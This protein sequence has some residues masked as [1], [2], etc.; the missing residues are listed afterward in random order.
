MSVDVNVQADR[1][2]LPRRTRYQ[3]MAQILSYNRRTYAAAAAVAALLLAGALLLP[4]TGP[5]RPVRVLLAAMGLLLLAG[6]AGSLLA[7]H[8]VYDRSALHRWTWLTERVPSGR[9]G[10]RWL[11]VHAGLDEAS[12]ALRALYGPRGTVVDAYDASRMTEPAIH[13]ARERAAAGLPAVKGSFDRLP[14]AS[15]SQ[16][17]ALLFFAAHELRRPEERA[18]LLREVGR[19]LAPGG[20]AVVAEHARDAPNLLAFG[21]GA[22]HFFSAGSWRRTFSAAGLAL[23]SEGRVTPFVRVFVLEAAP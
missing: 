11:V 8:A 10:L 15:A 21:P 7:S 13:V 20:R 2:R 12:P 17:L 3:G 23:R 22:L 18:A 19:T 4:A 6:T 9:H 1:P 5:V 16:D 14:V